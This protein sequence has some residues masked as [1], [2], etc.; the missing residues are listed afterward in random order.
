[1][2][3]H[4]AVDADRVSA[5]GEKPQKAGLSRRL[6]ELDWSRELPWDI[7]GVAVLR[8][9]RETAFP[10]IEAH[11]PRIFGVE[12]GRFLVEEMTEAKRRFWDEMD[13]YL[14]VANGRTV[15]VCAGHPSDWSTYYVRTVAILP[16]LRERH[17]VTRFAEGLAGVLREA[18]VARFEAE[19]S[20]ANPAMMR[21][22]ANLGF[23]VTS[24]TQTER[25]GT[26]LRLTK[27]LREDA[28]E[29]FRRQFICMSDIEP[30]TRK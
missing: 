26:M 1:M 2:R 21:L 23:L 19:C 22:F 25:W 11:Y 27:F 24:T 4:S 20:P 13:V 30:K 3:G 7:G 5:V 28:E 17:V 16:E 14:F 15:G 10:F 18:G 6:W 12:P 29:A 8:G 9:S